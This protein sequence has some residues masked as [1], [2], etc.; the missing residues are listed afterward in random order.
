MKWLQKYANDKATLWG[1]VIEAK[2]EEEDIWMTNE[3]TTPYGDNLW[4]SMLLQ[5]QGIQ[6][7]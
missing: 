7:G 2:Y 1:R 5:D 6:W 3:I 4:R